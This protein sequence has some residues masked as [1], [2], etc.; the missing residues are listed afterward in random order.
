MMNA[1]GSGQKKVFND[2]KKQRDGLQQF[3]MSAGEVFVIKG[4][5]IKFYNIL[6]YSS[7][8]KEVSLRIVKQ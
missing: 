3:Y 5:G 4:I 1:E 8:D 6:S 7:S 2:F